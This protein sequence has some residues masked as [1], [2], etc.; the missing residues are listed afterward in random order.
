[1][2]EILKNP[3]KVEFIKRLASSSAPCLLRKNGLLNDEKE[4]ANIGEWPLEEISAPTLIIHGACDGDV[5][6]EHAHY[7]AEKIPKAKKIIS[8]QGFHLLELGN[9][10]NDLIQCRLDFFRSHR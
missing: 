3:C 10:Y 9:D 1:M 7:A 8:R 5:G 2:D 6:I 4:M